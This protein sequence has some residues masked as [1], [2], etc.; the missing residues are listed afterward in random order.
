M[1]RL[2]V[3]F[4]RMVQRAAQVPNRVPLTAGTH[5]DGGIAVYGQLKAAGFDMSPDADLLGSESALRTASALVYRSPIG[6]QDLNANGN[7]RTRSTF[8]PSASG[9]R[10]VEEKQKIDRRAQ[11]DRDAALARDA[12]AREE[13]IVQA[14]GERRL[15]DAEAEIERLR[16]NLAVAEKRAKQ[17]GASNDR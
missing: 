7:I 4:V 5:I 8:L 3:Q 17:E 16:H 10:Q 9:Q 15:K 14:A 12:K 6:G 2:T 1:D 13:A 11:A